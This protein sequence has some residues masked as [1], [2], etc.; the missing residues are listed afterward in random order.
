VRTCYVG[1]EEP[2]NAAA[3]TQVV[4]GKAGEVLPQLFRIDE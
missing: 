1:P 2:L 4:L 3:F